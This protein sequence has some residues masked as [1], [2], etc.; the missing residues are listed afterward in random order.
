MLRDSLVF[1]LVFKSTSQGY[2]KY[3]NFNIGQLFKSS[4]F[5]ICNELLSNLDN[6]LPSNKLPP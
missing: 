6:Y 3:A 5:I 4:Y 1:H 2:E